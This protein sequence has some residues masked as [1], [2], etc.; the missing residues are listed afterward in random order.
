EATLVDLGSQNGTQLNGERVVG[1]RMLASGDA[2]VVGA[3]TLLYHGGARAA[4]ARGVVPFAS[5]RQRCEEEL[6]RSLRYHRPLSGACL[7]LATS[8][9]DRPLAARA[10]EG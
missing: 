10:L 6:E 2:I 9:A 5:F 1:S 8:D 3:I 4:A 7:A